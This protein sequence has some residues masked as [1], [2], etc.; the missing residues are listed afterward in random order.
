MGSDEI[1]CTF[2]ITNHQIPA[3]EAAF[4]AAVEE[5]AGV[6]QADHAADDQDDDGQDQV[7]DLAVGVELHL[8]SVGIGALLGGVQVT[9][10]GVVLMGLH[11]AEVD[12]QSGGQ[13]DHDQ[14]QDSV[15]VVGDSLDEE[16][17][18]LTFFSIA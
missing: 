15:E 4:D 8:G 16:F 9:V 13:E 18:A 3:A 10:G 11:G 17:E 7:D 12:V 14:G 6:D 5:A 1:F 2:G